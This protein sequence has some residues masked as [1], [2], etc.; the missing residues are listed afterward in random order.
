MAK[1]KALL[2]GINDYATISDLRGCL[3]DISNI[4]DVLKT[5]YGFTNNDIRVLLDSRATAA[6]VR[7]RMDWLRKDM[8]AGDTIFFHFSGHGCFSGDTQISLL[9]GRNVSL[10]ELERTYKDKS[11]W[12]YSI[13][14]EGKV[15]PGKAHSP[16]ITK[17]SKVLDVLLD[18]GETIRCTPDHRFM[19]HDGTYKEAT[20]LSPGTSLMPLYKRLSN[21]ELTVLDH[22]VVSVSEVSDTEIPVYD[23]TVEE[24]H[25]FALSSGV[26]VHNSQVRDRDGDELKDH[27]D[28][29]LCMYGMNWNDGYLLD[30]EFDAFFKS[31][32]LGVTCE[33]VF[34]SCHS[35]TGNSVD[36]NNVGHRSQLAE[37]STDVVGRFLPPPVDIEM[38]WEGDA[39]ETKRFVNAVIPPRWEHPVPPTQVPHSIIWSGC[40]EEQTSADA[41]INGSFNG[42][43]TYYFCKLIRQTQGK[44]TRLDLLT[45]LRASLKHHRYTQIPELTCHGSVA[46]INFLS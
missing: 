6:E 39:I 45:R 38:R 42:A 18:T 20:S 15:V 13:N 31:L 27:L 21:E 1:K 34:D 36:R 41:Q 32:P 40:G 19:L 4:R 33:V 23:I 16:R 7:V 8:V 11:F 22:K 28:E 26:F 35:G 17:F 24:Y 3:N 30:D 25:N 14:D 44:I 37:A 5:Y 2:V 43:F 29:I 9:D 12:V 10:E 46:S